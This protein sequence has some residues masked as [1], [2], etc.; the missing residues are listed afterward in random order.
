MEAVA[1]RGV[2][3]VLAYVVAACPTLELQALR[4]K[5]ADDKGLVVVVL[6]VGGQLHCAEFEV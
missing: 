5:E 3:Q 6:E 2:M 4:L 1:G